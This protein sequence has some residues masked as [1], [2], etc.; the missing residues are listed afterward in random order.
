MYLVNTFAAPTPSRPLTNPERVPHDP[1]YVSPQ[2]LP[3]DAPS[4]SWF[5]VSVVIVVDF[6]E[7]QAKFIRLLYFNRHLPKIFRCRVVKNENFYASF[8]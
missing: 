7:F 5:K 4:G 3:Q 2:D 8:S 1:P 6:L